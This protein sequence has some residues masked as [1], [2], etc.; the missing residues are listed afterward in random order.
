MARV[1]LPQVAPILTGQLPDTLDVGASYLDGMAGHLLQ[2]P[3]EKG[4]TLVMWKS[5]V[6]I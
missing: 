1:R 4:T 3:S 6:Q 2:W 5:S